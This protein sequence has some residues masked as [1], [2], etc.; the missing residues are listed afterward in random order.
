MVESDFH[1]RIYNKIDCRTNP[2]NT[3][4]A[5]VTIPGSIKL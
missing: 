4:A 5:A 2:A 1:H 3:E